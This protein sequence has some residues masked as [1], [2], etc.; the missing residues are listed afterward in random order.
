MIISKKI[1][2]GKSGVYAIKNKTNKKI[3]IGQSENLYMRYQSHKSALKAGRHPNREMQNDYNKRHILV[4]Y[5]LET[6]ESHGSRKR[7]EKENYYLSCYAFKGIELY[8][9]GCKEHYYERY[10]AYAS[11]KM[12]I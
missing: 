1:E 7:L 3:Y 5:P 2:K 12:K 6:I 11:S 4:F 9:S 8:N 10:F